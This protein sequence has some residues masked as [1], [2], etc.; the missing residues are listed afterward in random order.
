MSAKVLALA[1]LFLAGCTN[2]LGPSERLAARCGVVERDCWT[3]CPS[4]PV[5]TT[6]GAIQ[7][8]RMCE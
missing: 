3:A 5:P 6:D 7:M 8:G 2:P 4:Q 1:L